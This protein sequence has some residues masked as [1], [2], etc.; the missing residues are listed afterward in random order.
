MLRNPSAKTAEYYFDLPGVG[1]KA[2]VLGPQ[3]IIF[4]EKL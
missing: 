2:G 1:R 3:Q 4:E